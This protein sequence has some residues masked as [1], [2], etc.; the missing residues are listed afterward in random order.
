VPSRLF[1]ALEGTRSLF[2]VS[3][4]Q[5][6]TA[7]LDHGLPVLA[8]GTRLS[9]LLQATLE[10][11]GR[12]LTSPGLLLDNSGAALNLP[13]FGFLHTTDGGLERAW[14]FGGRSGA[15]KGWNRL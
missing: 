1:G 6:V 10:G 13:G 2:A 3:G 4:L 9:G 12:T 11:W 5:P 8:G 14:R 15:V 7:P